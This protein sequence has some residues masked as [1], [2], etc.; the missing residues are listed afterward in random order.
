MAVICS[1]S[2]IAPGLRAQIPDSF[3]NLR[4]LPKDIK[5]D[6]LVQIMRGFSLQLNVRCQYC[7]VGGDGVSFEGVEF[8]KDDDPDKV[9]ARFMLQ[10]VDSLNRVVLPNLPGLAGSPIRM[11]CKTCHRGAPR[12]YLLTQLLERVRDSAGIEAAVVRYREL[13]QNLGMAGRF[14]FGEWEMNL[15]AER[16]AKAGR[17]S[18]AITVYQLNLEFFPQSGS[19]L[20]AL[21]QLYEPIDRT[22]AIEFYERVLMVAPRNPEV[23]RRLERLKADTSRAAVPAPKPSSKRRDN[24]G[25]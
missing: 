14:D 1:A 20:G 19:I 18:D 21:G 17:A 15:W 6:S 16:L 23:L 7:H 22:R 13:R 11:E 8:S 24:R 25:A 2:G 4:V 9:K 5:R 10:M 12:P 3:T